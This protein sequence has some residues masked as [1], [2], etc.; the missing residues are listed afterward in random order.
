MK[1][2]IINLHIGCSCWN[3]PE[4]KNSFYENIPTKNYF[5]AYSEIFDTV[6][7]NNT[8]YKFP[9]V[10]NIK[11]WKNE[12]PKDFIFSIKAPR[13]ITHFNNRFNNKGLLYNFY[14]TIS[15]LE[16]KLG[17]VLF[18]LPPT[19]KY[20]KT[21]LNKIIENIDYNYKNVIEFRHNSWW[22]KNVFKE[23]THY[24]IIFCNVSSPIKDR[25]IHHTA[26]DMFIRFH[27]VTD[28]YD[29]NYSEAE[30]KE[31]V[32]IISEYKPKSLWAYFNNTNK[33]N[34]AYNAMSFLNILYEEN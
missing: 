21:L 9:S 33:G 5:K 14:S 15:H 11:K 28:W 13:I 25:E 23:F 30:L 16:E 1:N 18:Q 27:G 24:K 20:D 4:W 17:C 29:H 7:I 2:E 12:S 22:N 3:Y 10:E 8:F 31:W 6:E 26:D 32:N 19:V 34:A